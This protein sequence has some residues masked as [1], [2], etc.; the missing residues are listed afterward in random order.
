MSQEILDPGIWQLTWALVA[1]LI[2]S[3]LFEQLLK[4][5]PQPVWQRSPAVIGVQLATIVLHF[6]FWL[7]IVQRPWFAVVI[8]AS[9]QMVII[10]VNNTKSTSLREPFLC[11]DFEYFVDAIRHPRLYI[12]FFGIGLTVAAST[13]GVIAIGIGFWLEPSLYGR[14]DAPWTLFLTLLLAALCSLALVLLTRRLPASTLEPNDDLVA[15]GLYP[16]LW[17]YG[18]L[19]RQPIDR[20]DNDE[21]FAPHAETPDP[22][23]LPNLVVV[24]SESF[25]DPR[26]WQPGIR[27]EV[28]GTYDALMEAATHS[29]RFDVPAWGANT[30]RTECAVLTGLTPA[31]LGVHRFNP[32][33]QLS[34][35]SVNNLAGA[36]KA[37]GYRTV[38]IHP[39]PATFYLRDSVYPLLGFD[40]F[41]DIADF[42]PSE[43]DG[44]YTGDLALA[45]RVKQ[46]LE[47]ADDSPVFV[48]VI[49]MENHGPLHL[50]TPD[51][52]VAERWLEGGVTKGCEDLTV[53]LR[54]LHN[55]DS[56]LARLRDSLTRGERPGMLAFYGDHVP[57][58]P[59]VYAQFGEPDGLTNY[60]IWQSEPNTGDNVRM[61]LP[62]DKLGLIIYDR[63]IDRAGQ[64]GAN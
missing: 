47:T 34:K 54:H 7:L 32:Y 58:M 48:F 49:S 15:M 21:A 31:R 18:L 12:P 16:Y 30:V 42:E 57:I 14:P 24:Q 63:I 56:M 1:T 6:V 40:T 39:Y 43:R 38:C 19:T 59:K 10:Q 35:H 22:A 3:S 45:E 17:A 23:S 44:Q 53:Y 4:P 9:L 5:R 46:Q 62:A 20:T 64:R 52:S 13:A 11:Q 33:H 2:I 27:R 61:T 55:T 50:E 36:L 60:F 51:P 41:I 28:L 8:A 29:G 37:L 26:D 25:F